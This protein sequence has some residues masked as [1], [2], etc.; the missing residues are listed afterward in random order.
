MVAVIGLGT[1][2][3]FGV[4][5][6]SLE[7]EFGLTRGATSG[8]FSIYMVL[9][10]VFA[11]LGG[12]ALDRY[13]PKIVVFLMGSFTGLSLLLTSQINSAWQLFISYGLLLSLGTGAIF[14][15]VNS[16]ASSVVIIGQARL[17]GMCRGQDGDLVFSVP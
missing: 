2:Y 9:C 17:S 7:N 16:T 13:G 1:R 10:C 3:S 14:T 11:V 5:F 4:F 8:V 15:V 12:R 6:K